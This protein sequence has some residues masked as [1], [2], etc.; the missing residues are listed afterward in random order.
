MAVA[1]AAHEF[2]I[3][4]KN[5]ENDFNFLIIIMKTWGEDARAGEAGGRW[6]R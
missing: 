2:I 1:K 4:F 6:G 5:I 3:W